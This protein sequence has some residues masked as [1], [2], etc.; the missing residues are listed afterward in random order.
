MPLTTTRRRQQQ[1]EANSD[2][3]VTQDDAAVGDGDGSGFGPPALETNEARLLHTNDDV[4]NASGILLLGRVVNTATTRI[5]GPALGGL[6]PVNPGLTMAAE[7]L[8]VTG[9][10]VVGEVT[11]I[12][13]LTKNMG[14]PATTT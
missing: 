3:N 7:G 8:Q 4:T 2:R 12:S 1:R 9:Q 11:L 13:A 10:V 6:A 5:G 14:V